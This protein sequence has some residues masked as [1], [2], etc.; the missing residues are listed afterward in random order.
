MINP[1]NIC[2]SAC[3]GFFLSFLIGLFS[4]GVS[5]SAVILRALLYGLG[6]A[7]LCVG[8][9]F[10]YQ[11]F[12]STDNGGFVSEPDVSASKSTSGNVVN[13]VIDDSN[14]PDEDMSPKFTVSNTHSDLNKKR[15]EP[16]LSSAGVSVASP[17][18]QQ[19]AAAVPVSSAEA[20][21]AGTVEKSA[22]ASSSENTAFK[23]VNLGET[24]PKTE[25][26][27][28]EPASPENAQSE[29]LDELPDMS[30]MPTATEDVASEL[31]SPVDEIVTDSEFASGGAKIK[32][33]PVSGDT[34]TMAKAIQ[35][36]LAKDN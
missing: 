13:I 34:A 5:F 23:P 28:A 3:I 7:V 35:T 32:E 19:P 26:S 4:D 16:P 15:E 25:S 29:S 2:I 8:I 11:K 9:T 17:S 20:V 12:L 36:L 21:P 30:E 27:H 24:A 1:K 14:L 31:D 10:L 22:P 6:F 33:Q 18:V